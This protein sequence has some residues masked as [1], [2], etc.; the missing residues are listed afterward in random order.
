MQIPVYLFTGFLEA[1]KTCF[2][3]ETLTDSQFNDGDPILVILC[4]EGETEYDLSA[5]PHDARNLTFARFDEAERLTPDRLAALAKRS[6]AK[7]VMVEYNGMWML[8]SFY[9]A[10]PEEWFVVQEVLIADAQTFTVYNA[11]MR[12]LVYDKLQSAETVVFN[13]VDSSTDR[14]A[15]HKAVRG[16]SRN[17]AILFEDT[18]G[19]LTPDT[20]EDPLPYDLQAPVV[21]IADTDY[22]IFYRDIAEDTERYIGKTVRFRGIVAREEKMP[23]GTLAVGRHVMTCCAEDISYRAFCAKTAKAKQFRTRDWVLVTGTVVLEYTPLY[24]DKGPVLAVTEIE[25]T[26]PPEQELATF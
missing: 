6:K 12:Q 23:A 8:D 24:G 2:I 15:L 20:I 16:A 19:N 11:N 22:A 7:R 26:T 1:G 13:R 14:E 17:A 5:Y 25:K 4:E 10:L 3:S 21:E 9:N 18:E